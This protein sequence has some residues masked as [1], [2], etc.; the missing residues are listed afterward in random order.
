MGQRADATAT[1]SCHCLEGR[2]SKEGVLTPGRLGAYNPLGRDANERV[3]P[4]ID[5]QAF[6]TRSEMES[7]R[8]CESRVVDVLPAE[9]VDSDGKKSR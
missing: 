1:T 9:N 5:R 4:R 8:D 6:D 3:L 2:G 7:C